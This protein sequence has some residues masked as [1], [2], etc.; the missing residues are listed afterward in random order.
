MILSG[1]V[2]LILLIIV[3]GIK[4]TKRAERKLIEAQMKQLTVLKEYAL[5]LR[6]Y[7][8][9]LEKKKEIDYGYIRIKK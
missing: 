3:A 8:R 1:S 6:I 9:I 2:V 7:K 4:W 5:V